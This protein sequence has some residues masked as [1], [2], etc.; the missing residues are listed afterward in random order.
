MYVDERFKQHCKYKTEGT[1][2][3][4]LKIRTK[5]FSMFISVVFTAKFKFSARDT[6]L[7]LCHLQVLTIQCSPYQAVTGKIYRLKQHFLPPAT[8]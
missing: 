5:S 7:S 6:K 1:D 2:G 3:Q 4:K 8:S